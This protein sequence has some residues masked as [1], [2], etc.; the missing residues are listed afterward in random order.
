MRSLL[1]VSLLCICVV[2]CGDGVEISTNAQNVCSEIAEV[3]CHNLYKCCSEGEIEGFLRVDEPRTEEQ[4]R[5]DVRRLCRRDIARLDDAISSRRMRFD[6]TTMNNC[7]EAL[8]APDSTCATVSST[9]PWAEECMNSAWVGL[10]ADGGQCFNTLECGSKDSVCAPTNQTC[11]AKAGTGQPC[12]QF[13]CATGNYCQTATATC[14]PQLGE[15]QPCTSQVQCQTKLFCD[16]GAPTPTCTAP[17]DGGQT[18]STDNVCKSNDCLAGT[19]AGSTTQCFSTTGCGRRCTNM[20]A[21]TCISDSGCGNGTC[22]ITTTMMCNTTGMTCPLNEVCQFPVGR[23]AQVECAGRVCSQ[24]QLVT[25][26]CQST[27]QIFDDFPLV[28]N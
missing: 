13:G 14:Q 2:A 27:L 5:E 3:A 10:V 16:T 4:C 8:V 15:G 19:C 1:G 24:A 7:L 23:C 25:D 12:G 6:A 22:S 18:C 20:P 28:T 21:V 9:V 11:V 26:Y 17:K